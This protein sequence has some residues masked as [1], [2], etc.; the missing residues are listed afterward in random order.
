MEVVKQRAQ[1]TNQTSNAVFRTT[2]AKEGVRGLYRGYLS[3]VV[4]EIPFSFIQFP[5]WEYL[6]KEWS[7]RQQSPL[8]PVQSTACGALSGAIAALSTTPLDLAKTR[9]MLAEKGSAFS[10]KSIFIVLKSIHQKN[11]ISGYYFVRV[12]NQS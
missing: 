9:I 1:A 6:K 7:R 3:T 5:I 2:L 4:R 10:F 11:G 8:N 12:F